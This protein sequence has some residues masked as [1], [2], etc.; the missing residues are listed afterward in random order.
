LELDVS[1]F[2]RLDSHE[3]G[4]KFIRELA[5]LCEKHAAD[6]G[7]GKIYYFKASQANI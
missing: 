1:L 4:E 6:L 7:D 5:D 2:I 3:G